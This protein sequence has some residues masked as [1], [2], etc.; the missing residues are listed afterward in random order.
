MSRTPI[1]TYSYADLHKDN[2]I[3]THTHERVKPSLRQKPPYLEYRQKQN[4]LRPIAIINLC[5]SEM[6]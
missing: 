1:E 4:Y 3:N 2:E 5:H 6:C